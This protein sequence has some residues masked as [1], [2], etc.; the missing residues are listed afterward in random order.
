MLSITRLEERKGIIP[1]LN[2]L[3]VLITNKSLKPFIWNICGS[4]DLKNEIEKTIKELNLTNYVNLIGRVDNK[5]KEFFLNL[6]DLFIMPSYKVENS[7]EG[8]GISYV[9]AAGY[10]IPSIAGEEG[11]VKDAVLDNIT[12]W[13]INPLDKVK[14]SKVLLEA[15]NND[16]KRNKFGLQAKKQFLDSFLGEKVFR[17]FMETITS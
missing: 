6:S 7:I 1:V 5:D 2:A 9:E 11:G 14:L 16:Q 15:I 10:G 13:C 12:G 8:F 4:G 3:A 17:K